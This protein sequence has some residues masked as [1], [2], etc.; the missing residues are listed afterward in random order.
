MGYVGANQNK[1]AQMLFT[2]TSEISLI[3]LV[4]GGGQ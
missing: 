3:K 4:K 2:A 1:S